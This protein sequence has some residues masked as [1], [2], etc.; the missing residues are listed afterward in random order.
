MNTAEWFERWLEAYV[1]PSCK[2]A[3]YAQYKDICFKH[4]IPALGVLPLEDMSTGVL[5]DFLNQQ[6]A[7]GN[8][9]TGGP[10]SAK[11]IKNMRVVLDVAFQKAVLEGHIRENPIPGTVIRKVPRPHIEAMEESHQ[12]ILETQLFKN[13]NYMDCPILVSLYT[14]S[15]LGEICG[16]QWSDLNFA[17][18]EIWFCRTIKRLPTDQANSETCTLLTCSSTKGRDGYRIVPMPPVVMQLLRYQKQKAE[19]QFGPTQPDGFVFFNRQGHLIDPDNLSHYF[20]K[21]VRQLGLPHTRFHDLRHTFATRAIE[22]GVDVLT[23]SGILGHTD[24]STTE[25][26]YLH[27]RME[28]MHRAMSGIR[29]AASMDA[30]TL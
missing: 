24:V 5:Q 7:Y 21:L 3:G 13:Q 15:R 23:L 18:Q 4:I 6:A 9:K 14:G 28:S 2:P 19:Q 22:S 30:F 26:F 10:L 20:T 8:L 29:P 12:Q 11:S 17:L 1:K 27:P 16:L 25:H